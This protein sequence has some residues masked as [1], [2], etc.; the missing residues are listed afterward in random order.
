M[1]IRDR[2]GGDAAATYRKPP[3]DPYGWAARSAAFLAEAADAL[4]SAEAK[5]GGDQDI[6]GMGK[7]AAIGAADHLV[8][9]GDMSPIVFDLDDELS[10]GCV[11][12]AEGCVMACVRAL[13]PEGG[14]PDEADEATETVANDLFEVLDPVRDGL[15]RG[16]NALAL[17]RPV[18]AKLYRDEGDEPIDEIK[19]PMM[20]AATALLLPIGGG[21]YNAGRSVTGAILTLGVALQLVVSLPLAWAIIVLGDAA[22]ARAAVRRKNAGEPEPTTGGQVAVGVGLVSAAYALAHLIAGMGIDA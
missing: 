13:T 4:L 16:E 8:N 1:C 21:H 20:A 7:G 17:V 3:N 18:Q 2:A 5:R 14:T 19:R 10:Y 11:A 9:R 15:K 22:L 6:A 12:A